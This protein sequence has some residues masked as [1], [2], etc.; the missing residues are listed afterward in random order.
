MPIGLPGSYERAAKSA[1]RRALGPMGDVL[2]RSGVAFTMRCIGAR[3][4]SSSGTA[5]NNKG[6]EDDKVMTS[7]CSP[8]SPTMPE[9][10]ALL[11]MSKTL[12]QCRST[13]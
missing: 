8:C 3:K 13:S 2:E 6:G 4:S 9:I 12:G 5:N 11:V 7:Q 1:A 10:I